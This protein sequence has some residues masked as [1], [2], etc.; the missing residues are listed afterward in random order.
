M[1]DLILIIDIT[2]FINHKL[3]V[4]I[5]GKRFVLQFVI[6]KDWFKL[7]YSRKKGEETTYMRM[8]VSPGC[9]PVAGTKYRKCCFYNGL[10]QNPDQLEMLGPL[11]PSL[12]DSRSA[13][14]DCHWKIP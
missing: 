9:N 13:G 7:S 10:C 14:T 4:V 12:Q 3:E 8:D 6:W 1:S 2:Y 11:G 5:P